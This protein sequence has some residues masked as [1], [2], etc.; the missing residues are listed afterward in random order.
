MLSDLHR[1]QSI[2]KKCLP[3][4][5]FYYTIGHNIYFEKL[6]HYDGV[7]YRTADVVVEIPTTPRKLIPYINEI[8]NILVWKEALINHAL[9]LK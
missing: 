7:M 9:N 5:L 1:V 6:V 2:W 4:L 3:N 8:P